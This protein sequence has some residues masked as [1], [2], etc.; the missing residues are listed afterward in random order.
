MINPL[1]A[2]H[3]EKLRKAMAHWREEGQSSRLERLEL[4]DIYLNKPTLSEN[5]N[6]EIT[7][8][9]TL[10]LLQLA[11]VA[12]V[13]AL[14]WRGPKYNVV[15]RRFGDRGIQTAAMLKAFLNAYTTFTGLHTTLRKVALDA[16]FGW[17]VTKSGIGPAPAGIEGLEL[18]PRTWRVDP[19]LFLAD[20]TASDFDDALY[21]GDIY[22]MPLEKARES[23]HFNEGRSRLQP[24][25]GNQIDP[26]A[27]E[28]QVDAFA[29]EVTRLVDVY[30]PSINKIC[31]WPTTS[32]TFGEIGDMP[33]LS[34]RD[35][36]FNPY[37][38]LSLVD[39][40]NT[41]QE[42]GQTSYIQELHLLANDMATSMA[43]QAREA[44]RL[45]LFEKGSEDDADAITQ[46]H[47]GE[48]LGLDDMTKFQVFQ[49]P[50]V[51]P[52][53]V[54][55]LNITR[56]LFKE[57][58][59]NLD[60]ALGLQQT[61]DT[62]RQAQLQ[63]ERVGAREAVTQQKFEDLAAS[64]GKKLASM[65]FAID[66]LQLELTEVVP[67]IS[68]YTLN[69]AWSDFPAVG[70]VN[71]YSFD[72]VAHSMKYR[73]PEQRVGELQLASQEVFQ[74]MAL[75]AQGAPIDIF[76]VIRTI[77]EY[78]DLPELLAWWNGAEPEPGHPRPPSGPTTPNAG[79]DVR[80]QGGQFNQAGGVDTANA[81]VPTGGIIGG[82]PPS[83]EG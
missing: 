14:A 13:V 7:R 70:G 5:S 25:N 41:L 28:F 8:K 9:S 34:M 63:A 32:D 61:A 2:N 81:P 4:Q 31:T 51:D 43:N 52:T 21:L 58:A 62:A 42:V 24:W 80:Y 33:P 27:E 49:F 56:A 36:T 45:L 57:T 69:N 1:N 3:R 55:V 26:G 71:D 22:L 44:K 78:R 77:S 12:Q 48:A 11:V 67:G 10:N 75:Q 74:A 20:G 60:V 35:T 68:Q 46:A 59:G 83:T 53:V 65:A 79:S 64:V 40:P 19:L 16:A 39:S 73:D 54:N 50:G 30:L 66:L 6:V 47:D 76:E 37:D 38:V 72:V 17:G 29:T 82:L 18:A 23:R 15:A